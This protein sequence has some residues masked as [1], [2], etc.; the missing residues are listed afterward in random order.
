ME[1][2]NF[3]PIVSK[4]L[5]CESIVQNSLIEKN[6][7]L[8]IDYIS[9]TIAENIMIVQTYTDL[10]VTVADY[11][12]TDEE[13]GFAN[14]ISQLPKSEVNFIKATVD[15]MLEQEIIVNNGLAKMIDRNISKLLEK[16]PSEKAMAKMIKDIP[17]TLG[18]IS[19]EMLSTVQTAMGIG[20]QTEIKAVQKQE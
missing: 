9:R 13:I 10:D 7:F 2:K 1:I 11:D 3:L 18:K 8:F 14:I 16:L 4:K 6:G 17:K 5:L 12:K 19:P 20:K 15:N